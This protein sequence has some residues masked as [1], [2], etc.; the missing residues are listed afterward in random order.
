MSIQARYTTH[1][2]PLEQG[3]KEYVKC[4]DCGRELLVE[5]GGWDNLVHKEGCKHD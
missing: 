2:E 5:L 1:Y 4:S 3:G